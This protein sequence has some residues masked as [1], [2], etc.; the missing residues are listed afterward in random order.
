MTKVDEDVALKLLHTADWHLGMKFPA[1]SEEDQLR[2]M[3]ARME[4]IDRIL[5]LAE[6]SGVDAV[7]CAGDLF[8]DPDPDED[9][10][11]GLADRLGA[12]RWSDRKVVLLPGN[13]DPLVPGSV[14]HP[15]HPFRRALPPW[16]EVVDRE[17]FEL[18]LSD[19][20]VL[21]A[22]PCRSR[23][24]NAEL[25]AGIPSRAPGDTR[26]RVGMVHGQT[27]DIPGHQSTFPIPLDAAARRGLDYL[28]VGDTH[29]FRQL[30]DPDHPIV[31]PSAPEPTKFD[32]EDAGYVALVF[33][34][35]RRRRPI[36]R[37]E[38]VGRWR[39]VDRTVTTLAELR[40]LTEDPEL[41][42]TV[43]RLAVQMRLGPAAHREAEG[44][45]RMLG[46]TAV[47]PG[48]AGVLMLDRTEMQLE[49]ADIDEAFGDLPDVLRAAVDRLRRESE[50]EDGE[51]ARRALLHL[52]HLVSEAR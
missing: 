49:T 50:G 30:G 36:I 4:V 9:W 5:G 2:L 47:D 13:H 7:L 52:Y 34:A 10:W 41:R 46:G 17:P 44:L 22:V 23:A 28:A 40:A 27:F 14:Y 48:K 20:A 25:C 21:Y 16:V 42:R 35:R 12:R 29:A 15:D 6:S 39:W 32:E 1:F 37:R 51:L 24:G 43:L 3:R 33:F 31:Y 38:P 11:R 45:L 19:D 8:E 26:I 18:A